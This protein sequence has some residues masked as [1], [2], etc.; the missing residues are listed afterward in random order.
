MSALREV[1]AAG[2]GDVRDPVTLPTRRCSPR[3]VSAG[4]GPVRPLLGG[5]GAGGSEV[6]SWEQ[7]HYPPEV[8]CL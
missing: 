4:L 7:V 1:E 3:A 5:G 2:K 6:G 8:L